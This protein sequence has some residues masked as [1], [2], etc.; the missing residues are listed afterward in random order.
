MTSKADFYFEKEN[1]WQQEILLL[2]E[3]ISECHLTED[4]KWGC[5]CYTHEGDNIVLIHVF[6]EYC[7]LLFFKGVLL[8]DPKNLLIQQTQN[9]Q[10]ARQMRFTNSDEIKKQEKA[11]KKFILQAVELEE[12]GV[13]VEMK[14]TKEYNVPDELTAIFKK[15]AAFKKAFET[16]TPGRQ[17][18]YL[19][20]FSQ[21]KQSPTRFSRIEKAI[22]NIL[23][24]RGLT[25]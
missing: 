21:A 19:L 15:N 6:K 2:R 4:L 20:H 9:V 11:I 23:E 22:P 25:D 16:L 17:R 8:K 13:K 12:K 1:S 24:E 7:A 5:P 10:A 18:G 14:K 3:I